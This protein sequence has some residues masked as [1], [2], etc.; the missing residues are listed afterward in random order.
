MAVIIVAFVLSI[1]DIGLWGHLRRHVVRVTFSP[2]GETLGAV[3]FSGR[4]VQDY[5]PTPRVLCEDQQ[6][7][8]YV[9]NVHS[10]SPPWAFERKVVHGPRNWSGGLAHASGP[11]IAFSP[12][13]QSF[14][15]ANGAYGSEVALWSLDGKKRPDTFHADD[16]LACAVAFS[17]DG[18]DLIA[19]GMNGVHVW[20]VAEPAHEQLWMKGEASVFSLALSPDGSYLL[21]SDKSGYIDLWSL[22]LKKHL[23]RVC[24]NEYGFQLSPVTFSPDG[25]LFAAPTSNQEGDHIRPQLTL[26]ETAT[27]KKVRSFEFSPRYPFDTAFAPDGN[28][29]F[30]DNG[31]GALLL[32]DLKTGQQRAAS[33]DP[34]VSTLALSPDGKKLATGDYEGS[35][36][37]RD[38]DTMQELARFQL[39]RPR[40]ALLVGSSRRVAPLGVRLVQGLEETCPE[41][42]GEDHESSK[43]RKSEMKFFRS[44]ALSSFRD[45]PPFFGQSSSSGII[46]PVRASNRWNRRLRLALSIPNEVND[47]PGHSL[48][49]AGRRLHGLC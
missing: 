33:S 39:S 6:M 34:N 11:S 12:D 5:N 16:Q 32:V 7:A 36:V 1:W 14:A 23:V 35:V 24:A 15:T 46:G 44:F 31:V 20:H 43:V 2:D 38:I 40:T 9:W 18:H 45:P 13:G 41:R 21:S 8:F 17:P 3:V 30:M 49:F 26:W 10:V 25:R 22:A 47:A 29:L 19:G 4:I 28:T 48:V 37:L 42:L 27:Q